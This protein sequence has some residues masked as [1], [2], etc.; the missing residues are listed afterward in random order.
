MVW[1]QPRLQWPFRLRSHE[2]PRAALQPVT[3][4]WLYDP[5]W[6]RGVSPLATIAFSFA[7]APWSGRVGATVYQSGSAPPECALLVPYGH[8]IWP[9]WPSRPQNSGCAAF[10]SYRALQAFSLWTFRPIHT[11]RLQAFCS[12]LNDTA[13]PLTGS[14]LCLFGERRPLSPSLYFFSGRWC[15]F[16]SYY[17]RMWP[18]CGFRSPLFLSFY[19]CHTGCPQLLFAFL[20]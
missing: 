17:G 3:L 8:P 9:S 11:W 2:P 13:W 5:P 12:V 16:V 6:F 19:V 15:P 4:G 1:R 7:L 10:F 18:F 14:S 20:M